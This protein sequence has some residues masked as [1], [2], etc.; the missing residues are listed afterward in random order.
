MEC[1]R[2]AGSPED[3]VGQGVEDMDEVSLMPCARFAPCN[4]PQRSLKK[5]YKLGLIP[6][7]ASVC[8]GADPNN[9][10]ITLKKTNNLQVVFNT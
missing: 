6:G 1:P 2:A 8:L 4:S 3:R 5:G 9:Q 7:L 10:K